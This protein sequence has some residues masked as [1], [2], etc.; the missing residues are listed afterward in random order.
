MRILIRT[1]RWAIWARRLGSVAVPLLVIPVLLHHLGLV[2]GG[3]FLA[4]TP[5]W[6]AEDWEVDEY[7]LPEGFAAWL[8]D[9]LPLFLYHCRDDEVV[10]FAHLGLYARQLPRATVR[11]IERG[12]HQ[13]NDDLSALAYDIERL[14]AGG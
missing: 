1:S 3:L 8:P 14:A 12:G 7:R 13:F 10:P 5:F 9:T 11:V 6:G 4:A 2:G